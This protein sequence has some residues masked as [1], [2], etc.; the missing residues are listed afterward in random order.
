V[1]PA[2]PMPPKTLRNFIFCVTVAA[3]NTHA[4]ENLADVYIL[5]DR[6][7][8]SHTFASGTWHMEGY[9]L[10]I[11]CSQPHVMA[12]FDP[13]HHTPTARICRTIIYCVSD[14]TSRI[15]SAPTF[16]M[17]Y[18]LCIRCCQ[19]HTNRQNLSDDLSSV[20]HMPPAEHQLPKFVGRLSTVYSMPQAAHQPP[21]LCGRLLSVYQMPPA[22]HH[23]P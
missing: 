15:P 21:E 7:R 12:D 2:A 16:R 5:C 6:S 23:P 3:S 14:T 17:I 10:F 4:A 22:A 1:P 9:P 19:P 13:S 18:P 11:D 20:Y 8:Q